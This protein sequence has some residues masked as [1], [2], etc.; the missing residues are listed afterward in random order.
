MVPRPP[1]DAV[2]GAG[3]STWGHEK[4]DCGRS[5]DV[6]TVMSKVGIP[7]SPFANVG[8]QLVDPPAADVAP[9]DAFV[10]LKLWRAR[11]VY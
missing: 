7:T 11:G 6:P 10:A 4:S 3:N 9:A 1:A 5:P 2:S 8:T